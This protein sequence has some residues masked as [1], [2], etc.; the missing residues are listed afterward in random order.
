MNT[1]TT[2]LVSGG[3]GGGGLALLV[4]ELLPAA[5]KLGPALA[6]LHPAPAPHRPAS[7]QTPSAQSQIGRW[8]VNKVPGALP[9]RD[10]DL[11]G[12]SGEDFLLNKALLVLLGLGAPSVFLGAW[13]LLGISVALYVPAAVGLLLASVFWFVPDLMI[14][15]DAAKARAEAAHGIAVYLELVALRLGAGIAIET[16]LEQAAFVGRGWVFCRLQ[17]T[18]MRSRIKRGRQWAALKDLGERLGV[19]VLADVAD[20]VQMSTQEGASV[21]D[22]V[23]HRAASL[24]TEQLNAEAAAANAD[25]EKMQAPQAVL[26][27]LVMAAMAFPAVLN[28]FHQTS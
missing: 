25:T 5:P 14:R 9:R 6:R 22:T 27:V 16:A 8:L 15:R 20:F 19:P 24:R 28:A 21:Y 23:R 10:L 13:T 7:R 11:L 12:Q 26:C 3:A 2:V 1:L 17:D 18:L 4:N